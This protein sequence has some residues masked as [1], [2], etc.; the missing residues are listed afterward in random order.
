M[1][2][3]ER[4]KLLVQ[5]VFLDLNSTKIRKHTR[6]YD[7]LILMFMLPDLEYA[8]QSG[9]LFLCSSLLH[10]IDTL[11]ISYCL[12]VTYNTPRR[13][14]RARISALRFAIDGIK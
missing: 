12:I 1:C 2:V 3:A 10:L 13:R 5:R 7:L 11:L 6:I 14:V 8:G 4:V 9:K